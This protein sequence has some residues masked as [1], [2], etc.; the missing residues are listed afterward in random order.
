M[1]PANLSAAIPPNFNIV[2]RI[3]ATE[4][5]GNITLGGVGFTRQED[6]G[7]NWFLS[8]GWD[9]TDPNGRVSKS[10]F[11]GLMADGSPVTGPG[12]GGDSNP[13]A[14]FTRSADR[15]GIRPIPKM[16]TQSMPGSRSLLPS[17]SSVWSTTTAPSTGSPSLK[18]RTMSPA[19]NW[20]LAATRARLITSSTSIPTCSSSWAPSTTITS[21]RQRRAG[22]G[23]SEGLRRPGRQGILHVP[24]GR[25]GL[26][27]LCFHDR[28]LLSADLKR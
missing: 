25:P 23:A 16:A 10:G 4:N 13:I 17:A 19:A 22:R 12:L 20:Q 5:I 7:I 8:F 24:G 9:H 26:G 3:K 28:K 18:L 14:R 27:R 11:G 15:K 21:I 6:N 1:L 2:T